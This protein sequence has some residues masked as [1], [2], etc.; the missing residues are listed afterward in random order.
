MI[1]YVCPEIPELVCICTP[2]YQLRIACRFLRL[3]RSKSRQREVYCNPPA[4]SHSVHCSRMSLNRLA[5]TSFFFKIK[6]HMPAGRELGNGNPSNLTTTSTSFWDLGF[7]LPCQF[8]GRWSKSKASVC[9]CCF[10]RRAV[11]RHAPS[12]NGMSWSWGCSRTCDLRCGRWAGPKWPQPVSLQLPKSYIE[13]WDRSKTLAPWWKPKR[14]VHG[15]LSAQTW[16][17]C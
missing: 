15:V 13:I 12:A 7:S 3:G 10:P 8:S 6:T 16:Y 1:T 4:P 5:G 2:K 11:V 14:L 9:S 17:T